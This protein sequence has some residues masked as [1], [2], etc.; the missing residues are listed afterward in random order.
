M[1]HR[2]RL[3][4]EPWRTNLPIYHEPKTVSQ[5]DIELTEKDILDAGDSIMVRFTVTSPD[6]FGVIT[7]Y[8]SDGLTVLA[9]RAVFQAVP[10]PTRVDQL[11]EVPEYVA[12]R[13]QSE[14]RDDAARKLFCDPECPADAHD[15]DGYGF[16]KQSIGRSIGDIPTDGMAT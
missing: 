4:T 16:P 9:N 8:G 12:V 2:G 3:T 10:E 6:N 13:R 5:I 1:Y 7:I 14:A 11:P 15:H